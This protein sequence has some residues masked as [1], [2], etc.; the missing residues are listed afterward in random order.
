MTEVM[1]MEKLFIGTNLKMYKTIS[2]TVDY[3][4]KLEALTKDL[5]RNEL[6]LFVIP[7]YT[8]LE[9]AGR[10]REGNSIKLGAQNMCWEE[11]GQFTGEISPLML[12][13][14]DIDII[15]IGHSERRHV[16]G[17][18]DAQINK[19]VLTALRHGF[20]ALL[21]IGET[22]EQKS[23]G[24][25]NEYLQMQLKIGL[26]G[27]TEKEIDKLWIAY[28][29]VWAIGEK[30]T[31]APPEYADSKQAVI[32]SALRELFAEKAERIPVLYGG[33]VNPQNA[34]ELIT[35]P[36]IDGLFIGRS[37]WDASSFNQIIT[38]VMPLFKA[39]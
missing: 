28:E 26:N 33:S 27:V 1:K 22:D 14:L 3:L 13:E 38:D 9:S 37:A 2:Q 30:G 12:K 15:E 29:P 18:T 19:K 20:T 8:S 16:F 10:C 17:E 32:K 11:Q 6:E 39:K 36:N 21:C 23:L 34:R 4:T 24:V 35:M 25:S 7:S 5:D 31:P